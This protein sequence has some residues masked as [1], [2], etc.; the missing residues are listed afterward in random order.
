[1]TE[2]NPDDIPAIRTTP[3]VETIEGW[4][5]DLAGNIP[6][7]RETQAWNIFRSAIDDL[8]KRLS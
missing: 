1:M 8:K 5:H 6:A 7:L 4:A 3:I 2:Q